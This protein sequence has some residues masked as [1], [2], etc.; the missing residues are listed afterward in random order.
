MKNLK[1]FS[2]PRVLIIVFGLIVTVFY[3]SDLLSIEGGVRILSLEIYIFTTWISLL[4]TIILK[5]GIALVYSIINLIGIIGFFV[6]LKY[7]TFPSGY[8]ALIYLL[9]L[10]IYFIP[11]VVV[12]S[13][14]FFRMEKK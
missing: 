8:E 7:F 13:I 14:L 4:C 11:T 3:I 1:L 12:I 10:G 2:I 6:Y 9:F 5:K